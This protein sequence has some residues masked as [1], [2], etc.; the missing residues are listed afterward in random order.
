M[1][2]KEVFDEYSKKRLKEII[3]KGEKMLLF[4]LALLT[5]LGMR[6]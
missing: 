6:E 2:P 3:E 4:T 1:L 5:S